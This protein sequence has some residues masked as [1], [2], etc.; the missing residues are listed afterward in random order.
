VAGID[1]QDHEERQA[2][3]FSLRIS[4]SDDPYRWIHA[5]F[6]HDPEIRSQAVLDAPEEIPPELFLFLLP[7]RETFDILWPR[8]L[9]ATFSPHQITLV[10]R[11]L[12]DGTIDRDQALG[13]LSRFRWDHVAD[14]ILAEIPGRRRFPDEMLATPAPVIPWQQLDILS[15]PEPLLEELIEL[16]VEPGAGEVADKILRALDSSVRMGRLSVVRHL[17]LALAIARVGVRI[18][19]WPLI[20]L[21]IAVAAFPDL[22][23][24]HLIEP[25]ARRDAGRR[26]A[27]GEGR[28]GFD[29][30]LI[31]FI[32]GDLCRR[33]SGSLDLG[34]LAGLLRLG[35]RSP[36]ALLDEALGQSEVE[37]ALLEAP[38]L[39]LPLLRLL[40]GPRGSVTRL[41]HL[42]T[43]LIEHHGSSQETLARLAIALPTD[44]LG[45]LDELDALRLGALVE[46]LLGLVRSGEASL[47][48]KKTKT[49]A[50]RLVSAF[51]AVGASLLWALEL[52]ARPPGG[53]G[54]ALAQELLGGL[55]QE[56]EADAL[57]V[58]VRCLA[59]EDLQAL[60]AL[61]L[62]CLRFPY[63]RER[64]LAEALAGSSDELVRRWL[65]EVG[66]VVSD[67]PKRF[68]WT[69]GQAI[70][71]PEAEASWIARCAQA[72][73]PE[74]V[75]L[76]LEG[77]RSG[78]C[79]ALSTRPQPS[80]P[81]LE[82]CAALLCSHDQPEAVALEFARFSGEEPELVR[83]LDSWMVARLL[84]TEALP[85]LGHIWLH[86]WE[87]PH[88]Q[89]ILDV[90]LREDTGLV[91]LLELG[92]RLASP[93][94]T[95]EVW[96]AGA[97]V[98]R[99]L[100]WRAKP[101]LPRIATPELIETLVD[102][103]APLDRADELSREERDELQEVAA[104]TLRTLLGSGAVNDLLDRFRPR[105]F[106][107][108]PRL[109][110]E[111]RRILSSWIDT[112]GI[113]DG[114]MGA[115]RSSGGE[116]P[117][118]MDPASLATSRDLELLTRACRTDHIEIVATA[119]QRLIQLGEE[120][121]L[122]LL[123]AITKPPDP[124]R[125]DQII[126]TIPSW[127]E[128]LPLEMVRELVYEGC[129]PD[130]QLPLGV[131][132]A[133]RGEIRGLEHAV[134]AACEPSDAPWFRTEHRQLLERSFHQWGLDDLDI[135]L[136]LAPSPHA[137]AYWGA[138]SYALALEGEAARDPRA[139]SALR[140]FLEEE[141][142][143]PDQ[144]RL[145]AALRLRSCGDLTGFPVLMS[146]ALAPDKVKH[147][148]TP[149]EDL[150]V[151]L[152]PR[153]AAAAVGAAL[154]V[155]DR[156]AERRLL[157]RLG[158]DGV[159][160]G[161][162]EESLEAILAQTAE[163]STQE[164]ALSLL[165]RRPSGARKLR[166]VAESFA[167]GVLRARQLTGRILSVAMCSGEELGY[168]RL[169]SAVVHVSP[170]PILQSLR[171]GDDIVKALI[172]HELGHQKYH[173]GTDGRRAW[174]Q[175]ATERIQ[176]LFNLVLDEHLER[177]LRALD[178]GEGD[179]LKSLAAFGFQHANREV[180]VEVLLERLGH[181]AASALIPAR[182][183]P[184][185][186]RGHVE[187]QLGNIFAELERSG[188]SFSRFAR[189]LRMGLGDRY[190]DP[191]V[192]QAL[193]LFKGRFRSAS[194][195]QL[196]EITREL[197]LI[198]G[199]EA[200]IL[201][202]L[203]QDWILGGDQLGSLE[204]GEGITDE[205]LQREVERLLRGRKNASDHGKGR[206]MIN[207]G[208][209]QD[210]AHIHTIRPVAFSPPEYREY[211]KRVTRFSR[212]LRTYLE[213]L[214]LS[215]VPERRQVRGRTLDRSRLQAALLRGDPR[216]LIARRLRFRSDLFL[217]VLIDC[218]GSMSI[219][220]NIE[221]A[222]H[223]GVL[224]AEATRGLRGVDARFFGFTH[225][226]IF[227]AGSAD[228][229]AVH[230]LRADGGNNDAAALWHAAQVARQSH[231]SARLLVMISDGAPTE[232]TAAALKGLVERLTRGGICCAQV[233]VRPL[234]EICFPHYVVLSQRS[235]AAVV[236]QFGE[237]IMR[238]AGK[239]LGAV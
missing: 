230:A 87:R 108:L 12:S 233:A 65:Q 223:F 97:N 203:S 221:L 183:G 95:V 57:V 141:S 40:A 119:T 235:E 178:A 34:V 161:A 103:L 29:L 127:T 194:M 172:L 156:G 227:D 88:F 100:R 107:A 93:T 130:L 201:H 213:R 182:L 216:L 75:A 133:E 181:R 170:L 50:D 128:G 58:A 125:L 175:S 192:A 140:A 121:E 45:W 187:I 164:E 134:E 96:K 207:L 16:L 73:L 219:D 237:V 76:C 117:P 179:L 114:Q 118:G 225:S 126:A 167:W 36:V 52:I 42:L 153:L 210:F 196:L 215:L 6:H 113:T 137:E 24:C 229:C 90:T 231:R 198:F 54:N 44:Q 10:L 211:A 13:L 32:S 148:V 63:D 15:S 160:P 71:I 101:R 105:L 135:S 186:R 152:E 64:A 224:I 146:A 8:L 132:L 165:P 136:A 81:V 89:R 48:D 5:L 222:K 68:R 20:P 84:S 53:A 228:R 191:K 124:P 173:A 37:R 190:G 197:R 3:F 33:P 149:C 25:E 72:Q 232:C 236:R 59:I 120:G 206:R 112:R 18:G 110:R 92:R 193:A 23:R 151:G 30:N 159:D 94:L 116:A 55:G 200:E 122:V 79:D 82:V 21:T 22:L 51:R 46:A 67:P 56:Q 226:E 104:L 163:L 78:L 180:S 47:K 212:H 102:M 123:E 217:G 209:D 174:K 138:V 77:P 171:Q 9:D 195:E 83:E 80:R 239:V 168:T 1:A 60:L 177:N 35:H 145:D 31:A 143:R 49:L 28:G 150:L 155:G 144:L 185:R 69:V 99:Y 162:R 214:G 205:E 11:F 14:Q 70:P 176:P 220:E 106:E 154:A 142:A 208:L 199:E 62:E 7:D 139:L 17:R 91:R 98:V 61:E 184:A 204:W 41:R 158:R 157:D 38:S 66:F 19:V 115:A 26:L 27:E 169:E 189:A 2:A 218:S 166:R 4:A 238:L 86:R 188:M 202:L 85:L 131:A 43:L 74:A 111:V 129:R 109:S 147:G 39:G 234:E